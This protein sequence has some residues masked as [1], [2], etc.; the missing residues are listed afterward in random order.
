MC[1]V[2]GDSRYVCVRGGVHAQGCPWVQ[3]TGVVPT[4]K[5]H[6]CTF[7]MCMEGR[8]HGLLQHSACLTVKL[9]VCI[10]PVGGYRNLHTDEGVTWC[11]VCV[12]TCAWEHV[13][14][15]ERTNLHTNAEIRDP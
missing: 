13:C 8:A 11:P 10:S 2:L 4:A 15:C 12:R 9:Q 6:L 1:H 14:M 5:F 3:N 7:G